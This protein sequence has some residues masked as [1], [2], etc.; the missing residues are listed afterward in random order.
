[1]RCRECPFYFKTDRSV[2]NQIG[3]C[4]FDTLI[5]FNINETCKFE[6]DRKQIIK[7]Y[8]SALRHYDKR[9]KERDKA[10]KKLERG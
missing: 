5:I 3:N 9:I 4:K 7:D 2:W 1:M 8:K 6:K 10:I